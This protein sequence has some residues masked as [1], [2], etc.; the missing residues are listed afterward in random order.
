MDRNRRIRSERTKDASNKRGERSGTKRNTKRS[1]LA[2]RF[3]AFQLQLLVRSEGTRKGKA[4]GVS[5]WGQA[6]FRVL[7]EQAIACR[8]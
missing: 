5:E 3:A 4:N 1:G 8:L 7:E 6:E 2:A